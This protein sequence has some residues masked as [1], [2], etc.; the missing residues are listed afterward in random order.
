MALFKVLFLLQ[1]ILYFELKR[2]NKIEMK[3][4]KIQSF[5]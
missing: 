1:Q 3:K 5:V 2:K 4:K